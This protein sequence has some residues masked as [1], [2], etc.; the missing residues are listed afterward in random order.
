MT[1]VA[2]VA[3]QGALTLLCILVGNIAKLIEFASFLTWVF[4]GLVMIALLIMR[5]TK[6]DVH[7][8]YKVPILVPI[9]VLLI[10]IY[11]AVSPIIS[12]P[13][14]VHLFIL[15]FIIAGIFVYH[16]YVYKN[17]NSDFSSKYLP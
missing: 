5:K 4:Y 1:P 11:L 14:L 15:M 17:A 2:A 3:L 7:R 12:H 16:F 13:A 10:S 8:P 6:P 9:L